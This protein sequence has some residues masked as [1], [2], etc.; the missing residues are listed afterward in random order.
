VAL[1]WVFVLRDRGDPVSLDEAVES[2]RAGD[3]PA[4]TGASAGLPA[5]GVYVYATDGFEEIDALLGSRH[6]Y[7]A[8]TT[9]TVSHGGC[10]LLL[11]WDALDERSTTWEV[12]PGDAWSIAG[13]DEEHRFLG[14]TERTSYRCEPGSIWRPASEE[15]GTRLARRCS[16]GATT[17]E[18]AGEVVGPEART[19]GAQSVGTVHVTLDLVLEGRTRGTGS[20]VLWLERSTGLVVRL[21]LE[22]DNR[23]AS[24]IGDV[25]Y[26][27]RATLELVSVEPRT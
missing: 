15:P 7:P 27:E 23:T 25:R 20:L 4:G 19:V 5:P 26:R 3:L 1:V 11:R 10:G 22:N 24:A 14:R 9:I 8:E 12:C 6:D 2:F 16:A 18:A 13:Y 21:V 17:E